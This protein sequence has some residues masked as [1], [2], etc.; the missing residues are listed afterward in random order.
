MAILIVNMLDLVYYS[1]FVQTHGPWGCQFF[2]I[3]ESAIALFVD[4]KKQMFLNHSTSGP[5][6]KN[7]FLYGPPNL[8]VTLGQLPIL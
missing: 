6:L 7:P 1:S 5:L 8:S 3:Y 2:Q 4:I